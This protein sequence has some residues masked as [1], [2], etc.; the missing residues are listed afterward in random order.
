MKVGDLVQLN[1]G[2]PRMTVAWLQDE[3]AGCIWFAEALNG[4]EYKTQTFPLSCVRK[5]ED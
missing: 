1:S 2:G 4:G 5:A 3:Q